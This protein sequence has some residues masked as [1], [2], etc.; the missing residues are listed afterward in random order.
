MRIV[1]VSATLPNIE[2]IAV[3]L[4]VKK[5]E[6]L[7]QFKESDR[8]VPL[9]KHVLPY[10]CDNQYSFENY[11]NYRLLGVIEK[12]SENKPTLVFC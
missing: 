1:A 2:D 5:G 11:L 6:G 7:L 10:N 12:Y 3:W 8:S 4:K 9:E